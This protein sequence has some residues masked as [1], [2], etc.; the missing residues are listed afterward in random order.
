M[1]EQHERGLIADYLAA[2]NTM[3]LATCGAG[4]PWA[5]A[6]FYAHDADWVLYFMSDPATRHMRD[7]ASTPQ[8]AAA[9]QDDGQPWESLRGLQIHGCCNRVGSAD[10][11]RAE[12]CYVRKFPFLRAAPGALADRLRSTPFFELRP[13]WIRMIDNSRGF[14]HKTEIQFE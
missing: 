12:A 5:A 14:G 1:A 2:H 7:I 6:V 3:T 11:A 10:L 8:V 9:V 4:G 13:Q